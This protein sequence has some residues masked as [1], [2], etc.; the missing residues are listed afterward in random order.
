MLDP[1]QLEELEIDSD[2]LNVVYA[3]ASSL[4]NIGVE[5]G[6]QGGQ[7][8]SV[9]WSFAEDKE[10]YEKFVLPWLKT[11]P[12]YSLTLLALAAGDQ[13]EYDASSQSYEF[14]GGYLKGLETWQAFFRVTT[15]A[16]TWAGLRKMENEFAVWAMPEIQR[17]STK[18]SGTIP[19][20]VLELARS[21]VEGETKEESKEEGEEE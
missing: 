19:E 18:I 13:P 21:E 5:S 15:F 4:T 17:I 3:G 12:H 16:L 6:E 14:H 2:R 8:P 11:F 20:P 9:G 10:S 7:H 1:T